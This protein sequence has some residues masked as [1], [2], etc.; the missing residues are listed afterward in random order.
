MRNEDWYG[1]D[2]LLDAIEVKIF[3]SPQAM[4]NALLAG[5]IDVASNVGGVAA[6]TAEKRGD[7][8]VVRRPNDVGLGG[9]ARRTHRRAVGGHHGAKRV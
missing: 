7:I 3:E 6:R 8:Q 2:V 9:H 5:Q 1:G 4:A